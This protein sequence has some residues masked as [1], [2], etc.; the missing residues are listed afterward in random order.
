M[1]ASTQEKTSEVWDLR[2]IIPPN[3]GPKKYKNKLIAVSE[4]RP[5]KV[6]SRV[7]KPSVTCV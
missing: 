5:T 3:T 1:L 6:S 4:I 7:R 2:A